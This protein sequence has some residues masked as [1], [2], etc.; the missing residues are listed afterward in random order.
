MLNIVNYSVILMCSK[1][2]IHKV[3]QTLGV[4][5]EGFREGKCSEA[6]DGGAGVL[7]IVT[8]VIKKKCL[9]I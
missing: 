3:L 4:G 1:I 2:G 8:F 5:G 6:F 7:A 9:L